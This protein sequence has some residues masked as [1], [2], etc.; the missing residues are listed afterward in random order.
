MVI[1][2]VNGVKTVSARELYIGLGLA[3]DQWSRW[4][5]TNIVNNDFF[6]Y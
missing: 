3:K 1:K 6:S 2:N 4:Y 5:K